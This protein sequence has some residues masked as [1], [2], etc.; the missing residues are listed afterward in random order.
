MT[1]SGV[2]LLI[3]LMG[4][5]LFYYQGVIG[6]RTKL[7]WQFEE[8][9]VLEYQVAMEIQ[10]QLSGTVSKGSTTRLFYTWH[11]QVSDEGTDR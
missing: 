10:Q 2:G 8:G 1:W 3:L 4:I 9:D 11:H 7:H 5:G 6:P